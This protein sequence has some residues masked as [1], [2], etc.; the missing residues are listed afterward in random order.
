MAGGQWRARGPHAIV[1][2]MTSVAMIDL[3]C[4]AWMRTVGD[5]RAQGALVRSTCCQCRTQL[6]VDLAAMLTVKGIS[7]SLIDRLERCSVVGCG[8]SIYYQA[9]RSYGR[10]WTILLRDPSLRAAIAE[11]GATAPASDGYSI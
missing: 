1:A 4:P 7:W 6:R 5:L 11:P 9:A 10:P 3:L 2:T 8:G